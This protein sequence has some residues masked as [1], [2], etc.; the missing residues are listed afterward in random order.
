MEEMF[1]MKIAHTARSWITG[2]FQ[3]KVI[4]ILSVVIFISFVLIGIVSY[5]ISS[6]I[7]QDEI[8]KQYLKANE[9]A[10]ARI[11]LRV[12]D[13]YRIMQSI[14]FN[15]SIEELVK[16]LT[17]NISEYER[18]YNEK[19][20]NNLLQQV[21]VDMPDVLAM[22][23]LNTSGTRFYLISGIVEAAPLEDRALE[24]MLRSLEGTSGET[25]C[26]RHQSESAGKLPTYYLGRLMKNTLYET[27]GL[28]ILKVHPSFFTNMAKEMAPEGTEMICIFD[29]QKLL[30][31]NQTSG[32]EPFPELA[33]LQVK[34]MEKDSRFLFFRS[35]SDSTGFSLVTGISVEDVKRQS[36]KLFQLILLIGLISVIII[37]LFVRLASW[38]LLRPL[39]AL[40]FG[41]RRLQMGHFG[42]QIGVNTKDELGFLAH[43]FNQMSGRIQTL[44]N[45]VYVREIKEREAQLKAIQ[46]Q[47]HPHFLHNILNELYW[48]LYANQDEAS[49]RLVSSVS[50]MLQYS[51]LPVH[52][53]TTVQDEF[54][55]IRSYIAIQQQLFHPGLE[56]SIVLDDQAQS[57]PILRFLLIPLI[58]NVFVH[59]FRD[60]KPQESLI[61]RAQIH[62]QFLT[63]EI[64]DNGCGM[65]AETVRRVL[66]V[67][68]LSRTQTREPIGIPSVVQRIH[69]IHGPPHRIEI[70]SEPDRGTTIYLVLPVHFTMKA[71]QT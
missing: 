40:V 61:V 32:R 54:N 27:Y 48:K 34:D 45:E 55:Q 38:R 42:E 49:V 56:T 14:V 33:P 8:R 30:Y 20:V 57:V 62:K 41:M 47:L 43:N 37:C 3:A 63:I 64:T 71:V 52:H 21:K 9:Q 22:Y 24:T 25:I 67:A 46:A 51:L 36:R 53:P 5:R 1:E 17:G 50:D 68:H 16:Q 29:S 12:R 66:S 35:A 4:F 31:T 19:Q 18:Y 13:I 6:G 10:I 59:A 65:D 28:L 2:S 58:E 60:V 44:I 39:K 69:L 26:I 70:V 23:L 11:E 7:A 15:P